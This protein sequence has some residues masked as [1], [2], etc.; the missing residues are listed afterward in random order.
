MYILYIVS[1]ILCT[2]IYSIKVTSKIQPSPSHDLLYVIYVHL[3]QRRTTYFLDLL[4]SADWQSFKIR[5]WS[6]TFP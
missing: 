6:Y 2:Y 5:G 4:A 3:K 1:Y